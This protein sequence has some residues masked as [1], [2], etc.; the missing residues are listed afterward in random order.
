MS[1][2]LNL[3]E[4]TILCGTNTCI[5]QDLPESTRS[6]AVKVEN[7]PS[8]DGNQARFAQVTQHH[9]QLGP[10]NRE[11][12]QAYQHAA[13]LHW[14]KQH[15]EHAFNMRLS[16]MRELVRHWIWSWRAPTSIPC[17]EPTAIDPAT[18]QVVPRDFVVQ[19]DRDHEELLQAREALDEKDRALGEVT[20]ALNQMTE[21]CDA[22]RGHW[23]AAIGELSDLKSSEQIFMVDD[24]EMKSIWNQ[25]HYG[26]KNF[27][28]TYLRSTIS[29]RHL[30]WKQKQSFKSISLVYKDLFQAK[31]NVHLLFQALIWKYI[32]DNLLECPS[33]VWGN[34][35]ARAFETLLQLHQNSQEARH[36]WRAQTGCVI[37]NAKGT[38]DKTKRDCTDAIS[39]MVKP[40]ISSEKL[41]DKKHHDMIQRSVERIVE[42]A[43]EIAVIFN[44]SRCSY[45]L[46]KVA[47]KER[48]SPRSME[49]D[50]EC[51]AAQV[52]LMV[53]PGLLKWGN[54]KG[55][56]Y[57]L[58]LVLV[59]SHVYSLKTAVQEQEMTEEE[60]KIDGDSQ[61]QG[62]NDEEDGVLI[63]G[64]D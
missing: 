44:Q 62:G 16:S 29:A 35:V 58:R 1:K 39:A 14:E 11:Q 54:S 2:D 23:Q 63:P 57:D 45:R 59:K 50:E 32:A 38:H 61:Q 30:N 27:A 49:F 6:A 4:V 34:K 19:F 12:S 21:E 48:F 22:I 53:S 33:T 26:I 13:H 52:D 10:N 28:R 3:V 60:S 31:E 7:S 15:R 64:L 46:R 56:D 47:H 55:E 36:H 18:E 24:A 8:L 20:Q 40:F 41:S 43:F 37:Q 51:E 42:K 17:Y 25:L 9:Q 5:M